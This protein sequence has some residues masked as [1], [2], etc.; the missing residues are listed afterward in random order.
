M[1]TNIKKKGS[2]KKILFSLI[3]DTLLVRSVIAVVCG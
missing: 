2:F 3:H 1:A